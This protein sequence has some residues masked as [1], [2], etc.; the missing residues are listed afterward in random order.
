VERTAH[1]PRGRIAD[2]RRE[3]RGDGLMVIVQVEPER[4]DPIE[5]AGGEGLEL[6]GC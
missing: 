5:V 1:Q 2:V 6:H 3:V 4:L